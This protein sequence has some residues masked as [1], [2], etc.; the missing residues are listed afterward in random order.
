MIHDATLDRTTT[1]VGPVRDRSVTEL[2]ALRLK[3]STGVVMDE[4]VPTLSEILQLAAADS[5]QLLIEI[6]V[7]PDQAR[8]PGIEDKVVSLLDRH[9]M[10]GAVIVLAREPATW[11]RLRALRPPLRTGV[12]YA[13]RAGEASKPRVECP[14]GGGAK[15]RRPLR[16]PPSLVTSTVLAQA[17]QSGV[18]LGVGP[19]NDAPSPPPRDRDG[20]GSGMLGPAGTREAHDEAR[21][22]TSPSRWA[23]SS[24]RISGVVRSVPGDAIVAD[25]SG[26]R[27]PVTGPG[28]SSAAAGVSHVCRLGTEIA[29][30]RRRGRQRRAGATGEADSTRR[31]R[32]M[33]LDP[34]CKMEVNPASAEAQ[35]DYRARPSTSARRSASR[36]STRPPSATSTRPTEPRAAP[37]EP[38]R[39]V[40]RGQPNHETHQG[41]GTR[42][43]GGR[44]RGPARGGVH[45]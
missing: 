20:R 13:P 25:T 33:G 1:G 2:R 37:I 14:R 42:L 11:R 9:R 4:R 12:L 6:K 23:A 40:A 7:G 18:F 45:G 44:P 5:R 15:R 39:L 38:A 10:A 21:V 26:W 36:G 34:V 27:A 16:L 32:T 8:Y 22:V 3:D 30:E 31:V 43:G 28:P 19:V 24:Q 29:R 35:S 17:R 41:G